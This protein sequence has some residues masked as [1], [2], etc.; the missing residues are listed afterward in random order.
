VNSDAL[1]DIAGGSKESAEWAKME[2]IE[3]VVHLQATV[4]IHWEV[5]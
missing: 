4:W 5:L 1:S 2:F 3:D